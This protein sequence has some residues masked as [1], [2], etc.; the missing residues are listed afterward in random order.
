M[1]VFVSWSENAHLE[2]FGSHFTHIFLFS[3]VDRI[4][5]KLQ[6]ARK[7]AQKDEQDALFGAALMAVKKKGS[8]NQKDGK[9]E[10][11][12]RD[13][14]EESNK[15]ST[16]RAM[17]MMYQMDAKEMEEKLREDVSLY[18]SDFVLAQIMGCVH[19]SSGEAFL[20]LKSC[21]H[22]LTALICFSG[23][24]LTT[25]QLWRI[26]LKHNANRR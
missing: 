18:R 15:K 24:S 3:Y 16:S 8:T 1:I 6:K 17:K 19:C 26:R 21:L 5:K 14:N 4:L 23:Y 7:K 9:V 12:G 22:L 2:T 11:K 25:Y 13:A 10:A 20:L